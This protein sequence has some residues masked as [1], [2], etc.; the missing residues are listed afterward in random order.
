MSEIFAQLAAPFA[1]NELDWRVARSGMSNGKP[2]AQVLVYIDARAARARLNSVLGPENW[3]VEYTHG[4]A[5]GVIATLSLRIGGEWIAKQDGA[6]I[7]DIE[8][9]KGGL[10][11]AFKRACA[12]WGIGEYLYDIGDSWATFSEHGAHRVKIDGVTHRWD[13][14]KLA[15]QFL[16]RGTS[17]IAREFD[18]ALAAH[19]STAKPGSRPVRTPNVETARA[20]LMPFGRTKGRPLGDLPIE[21][22]RKARAWAEDNGKSYPEFMAA[23]AVLLAN[24]GEAAA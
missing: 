22:L 5:N 14:P 13:P 16:P 17:A 15:P 21:D 18:E 9:V 10:S 3:K 20:T 7:T 24:G 2:W 1:P 19:D 6:D 4:P 12:V 11:G 8:P 23:S